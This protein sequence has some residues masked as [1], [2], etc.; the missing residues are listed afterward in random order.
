MYTKHVFPFILHLTHTSFHSSP[1]LFLSFF[2]SLTIISIIFLLLP[3]ID[4][5]YP[6]LTFI[7]FL[8]TFC[9]F[10]HRT[11]YESL[12]ASGLPAPTVL[13]AVGILMHLPIRNF[14]LS[15]I[16]F[17]K[18]I[19]LPLIIS[20]ISAGQLL[21]ISC[22]QLSHALP[23]SSFIPGLKGLFWSGGQAWP[24]TVNEERPRVSV[25]DKLYT[26]TSWNW[27]GK[28]KIFLLSPLPIGSS[29]FLQMR[30][31][32]QCSGARDSWGGEEWSCVP[33]T[34]WRKSLLNHHHHQCLWTGLHSPLPLPS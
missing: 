9:T 13:N 11:V 10:A 20:Q 19:S 7:S 5:L 27:E 3:C 16:S 25:S 32:W 12:Q 33:R 24:E 31:W 26:G 30:G 21:C 4:V 34:P 1:C 2:Y 17:P 23:S 28:H 8:I 6:V 22:L 15:A 18:S 14:W 29:L